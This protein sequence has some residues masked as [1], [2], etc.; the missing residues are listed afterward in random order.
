MLGDEVVFCFGLSSS[1]RLYTS[2]EQ[3]GD[4]L[5]FSTSKKQIY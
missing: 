5:K 3:A 4:I 2:K 1:S